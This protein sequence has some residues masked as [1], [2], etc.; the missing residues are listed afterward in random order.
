MFVVEMK[1][2]LKKQKEREVIVFAE[3]MKIAGHQTD[4]IRADIYH[5]RNYHNSTLIAKNKSQV[6]YGTHERKKYL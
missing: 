3:G 5:W 6:F 2:D 1:S 4:I